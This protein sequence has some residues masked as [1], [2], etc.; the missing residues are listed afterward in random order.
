M[1]MGPAITHARETFRKLCAELEDLWIEKEAYRDFMLTVGMTTPEHL[2]QLKSVALA[3]P[4]IR[5]ETREQFS[6]M[7]KALN[8]VGDAAL[9]EDLSKLPPPS[10]KPN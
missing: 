3:D 2:D 1:D 7:W 10:G 9:F 5:K 8:E 4:E 6:D